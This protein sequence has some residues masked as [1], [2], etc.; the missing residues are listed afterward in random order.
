MDGEPVADEAAEATDEE[1]AQVRAWIGEA[2]RIV[3]LTGA[4]IS[5]ESGIPDYRGPQGVWTR[6]PGAERMATLEHY[7]SDPETRRQSW[8]SRLGHPAWSAEPNAGHLALVALERQGRLDTL[9]TQNV[10]GL[11][12]IAGSDP[13]LVVEVHG[14]M[15]EVVCMSCDERA[16]MER[17][18]DRVRAGE[19]DPSCRSCG[20][21]L[22]SATISFGQNLVADDLRRAAEAARRCDLLLAVGSTLA[23]YPVAE[24]VPLAGANGARVV[25]VN[26]S[27]T[28]MDPVADIVLRGPIGD[29]LPRLVPSEGLG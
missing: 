22:K 24:V 5:T 16:P 15:R 8:R 4:G 10:D 14:N 6:N 13:A 29:I 21:I 19:D 2:N 20:G 9:I 11:H 27:A 18:L 17:A 25:I 7:M 1:I 12:H 28:V 3:V 26:G 23:V